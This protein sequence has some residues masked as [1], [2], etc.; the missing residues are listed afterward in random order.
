VEGGRER[1]R[2]RKRERERGDEITSYTMEKERLGLRLTV[3]IVDV[4][5]T[6][7]VILS[8]WQ[9]SFILS[10]YAKRSL[11]DLTSGH[12][13]ATT[14]VSAHKDS[15]ARAMSLAVMTRSMTL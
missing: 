15:P 4:C 9:C 2:E 12:W 6:V 10:M 1:K 14:P 13:L 8:W 7:D 11:L 3:S 5:F